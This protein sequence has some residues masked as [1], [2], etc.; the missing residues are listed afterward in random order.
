I[1]GASHTMIFV[2]IILPL[3]M[4]I[5]VFIAVTN[6]IGPWMDFILARLIIRSNEKKTLAV[7]LYEM[8][9]GQ[10][11]TEYTMF[12]AGAVLVAIPITI[13][14]IFLQKHMVEGLRAGANK[15]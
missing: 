5:I 10:Q 15:S 12:A 7:G 14:F 11:N 13:L 1:D 6:F 8:V 9:T 2:R 4:P 3:S